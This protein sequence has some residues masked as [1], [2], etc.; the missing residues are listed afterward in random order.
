MY[1]LVDGSIYIACM[2]SGGAKPSSHTLRNVDLSSNYMHAA[3]PPEML[4]TKMIW[5]LYLNLVPHFHLCQWISLSCLCH[6]LVTCMKNIRVMS[7][8]VV[9]RCTRTPVC[10]IK[11]VDRIQSMIES[12]FGLELVLKRWYTYIWA[13][14]HVLINLPSPSRRARYIPMALQ[15]DVGPFD[16][17]ISIDSPIKEN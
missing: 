13:Y 10:A 4:H 8:C 1:T 5:K 7:A 3:I 14:L 2:E 16:S 11:L 6:V 17:Y 12:W 9:S 15:S